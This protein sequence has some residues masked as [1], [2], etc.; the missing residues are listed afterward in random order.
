MLRAITI[1]TLSA[2]ALTMLAASSAPAQR[3]RFCVAGYAC[4][5]SSP[6]RY[7]ACFELA[8]RRGLTVSRGDRRNLNR[9]IVQCLNGR[10]P[11]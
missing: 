5:P 8:L 9:F 6:A 1:V 7:N 4:A 11:F 10:I 2:G 3:S